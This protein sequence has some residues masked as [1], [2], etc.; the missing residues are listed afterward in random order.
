MIARMSVSAEALR[1]LAGT[2]EADQAVMLARHKDLATACLE[3]GCLVLSNSQETADF[4]A[5]LN[6][7]R[8]SSPGAFKLWAETFTTLREKRRVLQLNP[9]TAQLLDA[10]QDIAEL[11]AEWA[12]KTQLAI[13]RDDQAQAL[14]LPNGEMSFIDDPSGIDIAPGSL[15]IHC[16]TLADLRERA[17]EGVFE[18]GDS[19]ELFWETV[20]RPLAE[21]AHV[22]TMFDRYLYKGMLRWRD[23][24]DQD[25]V[26]WLLSRIDELDPSARRQVVLMGAI[27]PEQP[28]PFPASADSVVSL[29]NEHWRP[30]TGGGIRAI[31]VVGARRWPPHDRHMS[32]DLGVG[33]TVPAGFDRFAQR[34]VRDEEG[35]EWS[36][37]WKPRAM[38]K[39]TTAESLVRTSRGAETLTAFEALPEA[40]A[41]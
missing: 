6:E 12:G 8:T 21:N 27:N 30:L 19:R 39:L 41:A 35:V 33:I 4:R 5:W 23:Y 17:A 14:G 37:R 34:E 11:R 24:R 3:H 40:H 15:A 29:I 25:V 28:D 32:F 1:R 7:I 31:E 13:V 38:R 26:P 9:G 36:Y 20:L 16:R 18:Q 10:V 22:I 2:G